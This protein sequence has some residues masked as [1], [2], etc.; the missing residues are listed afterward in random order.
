MKIKIPV[1]EEA[2][3]DTMFLKFGIT[4]KNLKGFILR[5]DPPLDD[6]KSILGLSYRALKPRLTQCTSTYQVLEIIEEKCSLLNL[7]CMKAIAEH[8]KIQEA[9]E[10]IKK[11]EDD[12]SDFCDTIRLTFCMGKRLLQHSSSLSHMPLK[13]ET[14]KF[15]LE[16]E[17][18]DYTLSDIKR[19]LSKA[20]GELANEVIVVDIKTGNSITLT[21]CSPHTI[22]SLLV[23]IAQ[24]NLSILT[25]AGVI[26][27]SIGYCVVLEYTAKKVCINHFLIVY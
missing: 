15:I 21:C 6:I 10:C 12:L 18:D 2:T 14:V 3:F 9:Q 19:L 7:S 25:E 27:L 26:G 11:Y 5:D 4:V 16:W 13:C 8:F 23:L 1:T 20:F 24:R 17:T 22:T